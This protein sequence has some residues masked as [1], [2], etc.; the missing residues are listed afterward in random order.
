[1]DH[2]S[3]HTQLV[4][5][6]VHVSLSRKIC[7]ESRKLWRIAGPAILSQISMFGV[8]IITQAFVGHIGDLELAAF[9]M[10][11]TVIW[12]FNY[13]IFLGMGSALETFCGQ[14][15][16]AKQYDK[17]GVN[18][19]R[20]WVVLLSCSFLLL[21]LYIFASPIL[22]LLGQ[23]DDIADL[24]GTVAIWCIPMHFALLFWFT[25]Q[26][27]LQSQLKNMVTASIAGMTVLIHT[28]FSWLFTVKWGMGFGGAVLCMNIAWW[29][30]VIGQFLYIVCG[31]CPHTW[32]GFSREAFFQLWPFFKL[33]A[34]SGIML[35]VEVWYYRLLLLLTGN[36]KNPQ[37]AVD[38]LSIWYEV[39]HHECQWPGDD[40]SFGFLAGTSVRV[41][42]ELGAGNGK[43][44]KFAVMVS[45]TTSFVIGLVIAIS[46]LLFR[47]GFA[48][49][50]T[51]STIIQ[52]AV[53]RLAVLLALTTLLDGVQPV[54]SGVAIGSGSQAT[55]AY[56]NIGSYYLVGVTLG[57]LLGYL[58]DLGVMGIWIGMICR[59]GVQTL[60][61][62]VITYRTDWNREVS[63]AM[64]RVK[65]W[66]APSSETE[67]PI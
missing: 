13:G 18:L 11:I 25:L 48:S 51:D 63:S 57:A 2:S 42:N 55:V 60:I 15:F 3:L 43:A 27:Y 24:S 33:S 38:S 17:L 53:S 28:L 67:H 12:G 49:L 62:M 7:I 52:H 41:S 37:V 35:C 8:N 4:E 50:F 1:M 34:A 32:R 10:V 54:L 29:L 66:S 36:L 31:G 58:T 47:N 59:T 46:I 23:P 65:T 21:P 61:L 45:A 20:S 5:N 9:S 40:D 30:P 19:Q 16:G 39:T 14:A 26:V 64:N 44:A 6:T 22:K 56:V